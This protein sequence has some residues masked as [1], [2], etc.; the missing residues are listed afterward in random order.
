MLTAILLSSILVDGNLTDRDV[1]PKGVPLANPAPVDVKPLW[2]SV[3]WRRCPAIPYAIDLV[4][5]KATID[6]TLVVL[7]DPDRLVFT[8][9]EWRFQY[10]RLRV[11]I[12]TVDEEGLVHSVRIVRGE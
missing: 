10:F 7:G 2:H 1:L 6:Q 8:G 9:Y 12:V 3:L 11:E 4:R 5:G